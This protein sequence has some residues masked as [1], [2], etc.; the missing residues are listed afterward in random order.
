[1][2]TTPLFFLGA[3]SLFGCSSGSPDSEVTVTAV[4]VDPSGNVSVTQHSIT[5]EQQRAMNEARARS[6]AG[7]T[8]SDGIGTT[9]EAISVDPTC[10][11]ADLWLYDGYNGT[12]NMI[13]LAGEGTVWLQNIQS[14]CATGTCSWFARTRSYWPGIDSGWIGYEVSNWGSSSC[15]T[16]FPHW[17]PLTNADAC[18]QRSDQLGT[19]SLGNP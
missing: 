19:S 8:A 17:G 12:G 11:G 6:L 2:K 18:V 7:S 5:T 1:M 3:L 14:K 13:C 4:R 15:V 9:S 10:N 16:Y